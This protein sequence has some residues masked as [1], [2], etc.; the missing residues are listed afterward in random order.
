VSPIHLLIGPEG[1]FTQDEVALAEEK[2][3]LVISLGKRILRAETAAISA[4]TL[5]QFLLG[6]M[7]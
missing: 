2:S 7:R 3:F 6:D 5:V 4:V 1:G